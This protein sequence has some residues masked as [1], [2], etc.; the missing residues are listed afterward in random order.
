MSYSFNQI[1][2][3]Q[4]ENF[5]TSQSYSI[6]SEATKFSI[7]VTNKLMNL[8]KYYV[9][10]LL[11]KKDYEQKI[12]I[13][14]KNAERIQKIKEVLIPVGKDFMVLEFIIDAKATYDNIE[15]IF[16][17]SN[18]THT[19]GNVIIE[20]LAEIYNIIETIPETNSL[21]QIG[22]QS[23]PGLLMCIDGEEIRVGRTGIYEINYGIDIK[24]LGFIIKNTDK[25]NFILDYKY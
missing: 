12:L 25:T 9:K 4:I 10:A 19:L 3:N 6:V 13:Q 15:F 23:I 16:S 2:R 7:S 8:K 11:E 21:I 1:R 18:A 22:V 24:F 17:P 14:V 5:L 20:E